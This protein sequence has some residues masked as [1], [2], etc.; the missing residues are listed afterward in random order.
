MVGALLDLLEKASDHKQQP[1]PD[2]ILV[3]GQNQAAEQFEPIFDDIEDWLDAGRIRAVQAKSLAEAGWSFFQAILKRTADNLRQARMAIHEDRDVIAACSSLNSLGI[4]TCDPGMA[5]VWAA[6]RNAARTDRTVMIYGETGTGK[7]LVAKAID[8]LSCIQNQN[9][10]MVVWECTKG[11]QDL[12]ESTWFGHRKGAFT[13]AISDHI[14][15]FESAN[16]RTLFLDEIGDM[17]LQLQGRLLRVLQEKEIMKVGTHVPI[18]VD[19]RVVTATNKNLEEMIEQET[20]RRDLY[21]RLNVLRIELPPLRERRRDIPLLA[22]YFLEKHNKKDGKNVLLTKELRRS[23]ENGHWKGNIRSLGNFIS[24]IVANCQETVSIKDLKDFCTDKELSDY[25]GAFVSEP[26]KLAMPENPQQLLAQL[27]IEIEYGPAMTWRALGED[28][29][30]EVAREE[31]ILDL[32]RKDIKEDCW[33]LLDLLQE[34]LVSRESNN[35]RSIHFYL[36]LLYLVLRSEHKASLNDFSSVLTT[37]SWEYRKAIGDKLAGIKN[38]DGVSLVSSDDG[39]KNGK[40]KKNE[41]A[42]NTDILNRQPD[43][44]EVGA[45]LGESSLHSV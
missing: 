12:I 25:L 24:K 43:S 29:K 2:V 30:N 14:G 22:D 44:D 32:L 45:S 8:K 41:F 18:K 31:E 35:P 21:E 28:K 17:P 42:L 34:D 3:S 5:K 11:T 7:E 19:V 40:K 16:G 4:I 27:S 26:V 20:F 38:N 37:S 15:L 23:L 6:I 36:A 33:N 1:M 10:P 39:S 13:G 9:G